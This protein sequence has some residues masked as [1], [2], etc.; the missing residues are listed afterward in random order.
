MRE[1]YVRGEAV[2][3]FRSYAD[4][5]VLTNEIIRLYL[6]RPLSSQHRIEALQRYWLAFDNVQTLRCSPAPSGRRQCSAADAELCR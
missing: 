5:S 3:L 2:S 1:R 4:P 6:Q